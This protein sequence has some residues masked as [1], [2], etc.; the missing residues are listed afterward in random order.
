[1]PQQGSVHQWFDAMPFEVTW[2]EEMQ[3]DTDTH[4]GILQQLAL[5]VDDGNTK[6]SAHV[7]LDGMSSQDVAQEVYDEMLGKVAWDE[8][9]SAELAMNNDL[10]QLLASSGGCPDDELVVDGF[11]GSMEFALVDADHILLKS[12]MRTA[13][14]SARQ[15]WTMS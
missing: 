5:G 6:G 9:M 2:D 7:L 8:E 3:D 10:L 1:M 11:P 4:E 14:Q 15:A 13:I 12:L